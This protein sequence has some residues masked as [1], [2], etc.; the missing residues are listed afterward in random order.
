MSYFQ[1]LI[2]G[3]H[4]FGCGPDNPHGLRIKSR[5]MSD[6]CSEC[7]FTPATHHCSGPLE[8][9]NGGILATLLDCHCI[10]TAI[11]RAYKVENREIGSGEPIW[12]VTGALEVSYLR[13]TPIAKTLHVIA[14]TGGA[15]GRKM[16]VSADVFVDATPVAKASV[17]AI[18][19]GADW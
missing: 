6:G 19:V 2:P 1:D 8:Y 18:Q 11:A 14:R 15:T 4:C 13:P 10:C 3:N 17:L 12:Y 16:N 5:W 7:F 9:L